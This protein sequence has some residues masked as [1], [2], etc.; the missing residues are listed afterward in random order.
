MAGFEVNIS[1]DPDRFLAAIADWSEQVRIQGHLGSLDAAEFIKELV[2]EKL[3]LFPH[4]RNEP[5]PSVEFVDPPGLVTGR[6]RDSIVIEQ[7]ALIDYVKVYPTAVYARIQ[8][9]GG[10]TGH[11]TLTYIPSRPYFLNT[12]QELDTTGPGGMEHIY[13]EH[14][15]RAQ[16]HALLV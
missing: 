12:V 1:M 7:T 13:Y 5:T 6:L 10:W 14:W 16:R 11:H 2:Q 9:L 4:P 3:S 15:E 8:E